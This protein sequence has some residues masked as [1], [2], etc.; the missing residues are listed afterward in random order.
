MTTQL[1]QTEIYLT[2]RLKVLLPDGENRA[3]AA[4]AYVVATAAKNLQALGF[5]LSEPL[6]KRLMSLSDEQVADWYETALPILQKMVGAHRNFRPMYPN[7]PNQVM[8]ASD[9]EL[10]FN[11]MTHYYGFVL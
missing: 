9:A 3:S 11:A 1:T 2:K 5:G 10:F 8:R 6:F 4:S 7:F